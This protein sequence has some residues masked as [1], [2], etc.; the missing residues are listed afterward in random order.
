ME[1]QGY[2]PYAKELVI[3]PRDPMRLFALTNAGLF[4]SRDGAASWTR[5]IDYTQERDDFILNSLSINPKKPNL[6]Y[7]RTNRM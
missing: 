7:L 4:M 1:F 2:S 6:L 3:D 5:L